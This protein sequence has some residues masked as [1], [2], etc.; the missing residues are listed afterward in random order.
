M[1]ERSDP[2][3]NIKSNLQPLDVPKGLTER[4]S[5]N[6]KQSRG[7][8]SSKEVKVLALGSRVN[9]LYKITIWFNRE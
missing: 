7:I 8:S 3:T 6:L 5:A 2:L 4:K 9:S 1:N